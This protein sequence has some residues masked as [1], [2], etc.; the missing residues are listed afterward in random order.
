MD[1]EVAAEDGY[2]AESYRRLFEE[3]MADAGMSQRIESA[4]LLMRPEVPL[5][6]FSV[7]LRSEPSAK[8]LGDVAAVRSEGGA[9]RIAISEER[10]APAI[11]SRL[12]ERYGRAAVSQQTRF[13]TSVEGADEGEVAAIPVESGEDSVG[14]AVGAIWRAMPEGIKNRRALISG[15]AVTVIATEEI[16]EPWMIE[17]GERMH[18]QG[19]A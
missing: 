14:D 15:R 7:R 9:V 1:I 10:Y 17:E 5:F 4:S 13:D 6:V 3:L 2:G 8:A 19:G 12:W 11:L 18:G 16:F